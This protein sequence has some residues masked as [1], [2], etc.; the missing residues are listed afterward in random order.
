MFKS[1]LAKGPNHL[2]LR[3]YEGTPTLNLGLYTVHNNYMSLSSKLIRMRGGFWV[4]HYKT[5]CITIQKYKPQEHSDI[6]PSAYF[7]KLGKKKVN[8][9]KE[10]ENHRK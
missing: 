3:K 6:G 1:K 4:M 5:F 9:E 10:I 8:E 7:A 2:S